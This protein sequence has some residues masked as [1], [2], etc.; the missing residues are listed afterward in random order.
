ME[1][2]NQSKKH[3]RKLPLPKPEAKGKAQQ[4]QGGAEAL[5]EKIRQT[6]QEAKRVEQVAVTL[7]HDM[8]KTEA[9]LHATER[10]MQRVERKAA[11]MHNYIRSTRKR[12]Q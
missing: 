7:H 1:P 3:S 5:A 4:I 10:K 12:P 11:M 2:P 8:E 9:N 6:A